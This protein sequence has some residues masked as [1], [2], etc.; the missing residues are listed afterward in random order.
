M[1]IIVFYLVKMTFLFLF[2]KKHFRFDSQ[3]RLERSC[4]RKMFIVS[5]AQRNPALSFLKKILNAN[6]CE[7]SNCKHRAACLF[8]PPVCWSVPPLIEFKG[9]TSLHFL[10]SVAVGTGKVKLQT[11]HTLT[12]AQVMLPFSQFL[13]APSVAS[14]R[15]AALTPSQPVPTCSWSCSLIHSLIQR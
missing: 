10:E 2:G 1:F 9:L 7:S 11:R 6:K 5:V 8:S 15:S 13:S 12:S 4:K 3:N 14:G